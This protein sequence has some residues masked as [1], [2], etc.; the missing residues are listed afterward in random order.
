M[1]PNEM[2]ILISLFY[3]SLSD[4]LGVGSNERGRNKFHFESSGRATRK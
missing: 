1:Q 2:F 4:E 3:L